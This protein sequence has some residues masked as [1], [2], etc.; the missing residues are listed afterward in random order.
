MASCATCDRFI[1]FGGKIVEDRRYCSAKCEQR[2]EIAR[3]VNSIPADALEQQVRQ[4]HGGM[5]PKCAGSGPVDVHT[6]YRALSAIVIT[7]W[8][9]HPIVS[10]NRCGARAQLRDL[11]ISLAFGWWGVP[12]GLFITPVQIGKNIRA[13]VQK[14]DPAQP[15]KALYRVIGS[16]MAGQMLA[17][18]SMSAAGGDV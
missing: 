12:W 10:C 3:T 6:S 1:L 2:G 13:L 7:R 4:V 16:A 17:A 8:S 15:S 11:C 5:C 9:N 14:P 18:R